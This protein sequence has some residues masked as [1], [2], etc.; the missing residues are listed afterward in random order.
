MPD[1]A[2]NDLSDTFTYTEARR[3]GLSDRRLYALRDEGKLEVIGRGLYRRSDADDVDIDLVEIAR[4]ALDA[5]LCLASAL[6]RHG[7]TDL[8]P[9]AIDVAIPR[10]RRRPHTQAPVVW[11]VFDAETFI[12][13][14]DELRLD[15]QTSI[16]IYSAER[17]IIDA[18]RLRHR[19][20]PDL[21]HTALKRWLA[22]R[23][24][25]P[26]ALLE[27]TRSFPPAQRTLRDALELL[28]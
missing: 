27:L 5:T 3:A 15:D 21:A 6:A 18:F 16:G 19:E 23:G 13:G 10:G 17:C 1:S 28:L 11:H 25:Q 4:R 14:R 9:A 24:S 2:L 26:S 20:G 8:I 7:L 22:R 12:L